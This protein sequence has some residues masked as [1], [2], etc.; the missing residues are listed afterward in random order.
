MAGPAVGRLPTGRPGETA[1]ASYT[2]RRSDRCGCGRGF[3]SRRLHQSLN[4]AIPPDRRGEWL[5]AAGMVVRSVIAAPPGP[6]PVQ[7]V[8]SLEGG[9]RFPS[10]VA[11]AP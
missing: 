10:F 6:A 9:S 5:L 7:L 1:R 11:L 8:F 4:Q 2:C 3:D